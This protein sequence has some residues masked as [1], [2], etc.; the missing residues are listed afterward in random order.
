VK[1]CGACA[2]YAILATSGA[3]IS[4]EIR[5]PFPTEPTSRSGSRQPKSPVGVGEWGGAGSAAVRPTRS[6]RARLLLGV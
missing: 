5:P 6:A 3:V 4:A 1:R 2:L